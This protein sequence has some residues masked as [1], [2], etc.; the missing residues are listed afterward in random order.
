MSRGRYLMLWTIL[1]HL[2]GLALSYLY[3]E[4]IPAW[5]ERKLPGR[6]GFVHHIAFWLYSRPITL[7]PRSVQPAFLHHP[8][9]AWLSIAVFIQL[10]YL[11]RY[12][13]HRAEKRD[14]GAPYPGNPGGQY[15]EHVQ[16][17]FKDYREAALRWKRGFALKT[18]AWYYYKRQESSQ[19]DLFWRGRRLIIEKELLGADRV[20]ELAPMLARE[21][22]YY[23]CDDALFRDILAY[24]PDRFTRWQLLLHL[25]G[26]CIFLPVMFMQRFFWHDYWAKRVLVA[27][28]FAYCLGQGH[29]LY[30][31]IKSA[32]K[33]EEQIKQER[34]EGT[35]KIQELEERKRALGGNFSLSFSSQ[36]YSYG[37]PG[38]SNLDPRQLDHQ[39]S[40]L[41]Q[42]E[43]QL[44][45]LEQQAFEVYPMPEQRREQLAALLRT[46]WAW[47]E[48]RGIVPSVQVTSL[49]PAQD[50]R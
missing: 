37:S 41:R 3:G 48:Q 23:N 10:C 40:Q 5:I 18:P 50:P 34:R 44:L 8:G 46:E 25:L 24:Y 39:L 43:Q 15:W 27:D 38:S 31:H 32:L 47:M 17:R 11:L 30:F 9:L 2:A 12:L 22:M 49:P 36:S 28:K 4:T 14:L 16:R 21:L 19:P 33:Q 35:R 13:R 29:L 45:Q 42:Q 20:Q 7:L 1:V 26:L 6:A